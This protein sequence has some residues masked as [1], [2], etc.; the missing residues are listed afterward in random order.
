MS[1][2]P[3]RSILITSAPSQARSWVQV[4]PDC[5]CVKSSTRTPSR[6]LPAWPNGLLDGLGM[7]LPFLAAFFAGL[8]F[9]SFTTRREAALV[10]FPRFADCFFFAISSSSKLEI[11]IRSAALPP[12]GLFLLQHALR[13][14]VADAAALA[15]R[16]RVDH[17]IDQRRLA[18]IHRFID[19]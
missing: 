2:T 13:V 9:T 3:G 14:E 8:A 15:A 10:D 16:R 18:G 4:G 7:P 17:G 5:T 11:P 19:R 6:A 12:I 1:P